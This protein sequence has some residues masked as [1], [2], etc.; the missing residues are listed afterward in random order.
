MTVW[1]EMNDSVLQKSVSLIYIHTTRSPKG[2]YKL[3]V[4]SDHCILQPPAP[5]YPILVSRTLFPAKVSI[6]GDRSDGK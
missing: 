4:P 1:H 3:N 2:N 5:K 6:I